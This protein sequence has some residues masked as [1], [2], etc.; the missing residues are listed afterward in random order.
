MS[1]QLSGTTVS[2]GEVGICPRY[3]WCGCSLGVRWKKCVSPVRNSC[4]RDSWS[5]CLL[6][7]VYPVCSVIPCDPSWCIVSREQ[8][9]YSERG[10]ENNPTVPSGVCKR[11]QCSKGSL[12]YSVAKR[13]VARWVIRVQ[14]TPVGWSSCWASNVLGQRPRK[15][16]V[17]P[18][19]VLWGQGIGKASFWVFFVFCFFSGRKLKALGVFFQGFSWSVFVFV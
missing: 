2:L 16:R 4:S 11:K 10:N 7:N 12:W 18:S 13:E 14:D 17:S 3:P 8:P 15:T 5:S 1:S 9:L 19:G 6:C